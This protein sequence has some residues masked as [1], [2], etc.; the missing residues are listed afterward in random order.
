ML[1]ATLSE[2][3]CFYL[4]T[5]DTVDKKEKLIDSRSRRLELFGLGFWDGL[6]GRLSAA[7]KKDLKRM[8][9]F[10]GSFFYSAREI[11]ELAPAVLPV[12]LCDGASTSGDK[13]MCV[14]V[15]KFTAPTCLLPPTAATIQPA[16]ESVR[17]DTFRCNNCT[18]TFGS[19]SDML[20]H[21]RDTGHVPVYHDES[22]DGSMVSQPASPEVFV[23]YVSLALD[24][25]MREYLVR[26]GKEYVFRDGAMP[27]KDRNNNDLGVSLF[28][29]FSLSMGIVKDGRKPP[30]LTLTCDLRAKVIRNVTVLDAIYESCGGSQ[31]KKYSQQEQ[32]KLRREW[33]G[34]V[35]IY[36]NDRK[37][38]W[39][40]TSFRRF[41]LCRKVLTLSVSFF[42]RLHCDRPQL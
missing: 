34:T 9:F 10:A 37:C 21:C 27:M 29:A 18:R 36:K 3:F 20:Q 23:S 8:V 40:A 13:M 22:G 15:K 35:V 6:M 14:S 26:W 30:Q 4:Y 1:P 12:T 24:R 33:I 19:D 32:E 11:K 39:H 17:L 41:S 42:Y 7:D 5:I 25:N 38:K 16:M 28:E 2:K 31:S